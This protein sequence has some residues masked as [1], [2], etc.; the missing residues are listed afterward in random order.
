MLLIIC[1]IQSLAPKLQE[2]ERTIIPTWEDDVA[3]SKDLS[4]VQTQAIQWL[5]VC[6]VNNN[7]RM[8]CLATNLEEQEESLLTLINYSAKKAKEPGLNIQLQSARQ[9][10]Q[11]VS[12]QT[13]SMKAGLRKKGVLETQ[14]EIRLFRAWE[15]VVSQGVTFDNLD[16]FDQDQALKE[17]LEGEDDDAVEEEG[18]LGNKVLSMDDEDD[19]AA[20]IAATI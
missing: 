18:E 10:L 8:D 4:I 1:N 7:K 14:L 16:D 20:E 11:R 12:T 17:A 2:S 9:L 6:I 15:A 19:I 5:A 3:F 13:E